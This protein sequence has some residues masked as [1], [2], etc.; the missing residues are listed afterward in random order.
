M[1][2]YDEYCEHSFLGADGTCDHQK[3]TAALDSAINAEIEAT[4]EERRSHAEV[5]AFEKNP[6]LGLSLAEALQV[7]EERKERAYAADQTLA[8]ATGEREHMVR[9]V[10]YLLQIGTAQPTCPDQCKGGCDYDESRYLN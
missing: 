10:S 6:P 7:L 8:L 5:E 3:V 1:N 9:T 4:C 2:S